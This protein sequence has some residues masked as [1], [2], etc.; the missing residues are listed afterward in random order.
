MEILLTAFIGVTCLLVGVIAG[1]R[2]GY[3]R[4]AVM[5]SRR[6]FKR[7]IDVSRANR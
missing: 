6:G 7:G 2:Y 4:G 3:R 1:S 5:G